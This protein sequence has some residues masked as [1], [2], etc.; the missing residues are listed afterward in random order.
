MTTGF[1]TTYTRCD[2]PCTQCDQAADQAATVATVTGSRE[3]SVTFV[4]ADGTRE[5]KAT[6][7]RVQP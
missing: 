4:D 1:R 3:A 2:D 7:R 6:V 5:H